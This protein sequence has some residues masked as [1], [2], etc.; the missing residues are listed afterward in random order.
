MIYRLETGIDYQIKEKILTAALVLATTVGVPAIAAMINKVAP[1]DG[2]T[3]NGGVLGVNSEQAEV[4]A[5]NEA[6]NPAGGSKTDSENPGSVGT[7]NNNAAQRL[8]LAPYGG[9][10]TEADLFGVCNCLSSKVTD[11]TEQQTNEDSVDGISLTPENGGGTEADLEVQLEV[12]GVA[13]IATDL[14]LQ[15]EST[16]DIAL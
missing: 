12:E 6:S 5:D 7:L 14:R 8:E 9:G 13:E 10:G 4:G 15:Q 1:Y 2:F 16:L 3:P 11:S